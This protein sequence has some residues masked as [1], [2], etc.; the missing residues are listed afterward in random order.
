MSII[1]SFSINTW[2]QFLGKG[3]TVSFGNPMTSLLFRSQGA[4]LQN[5]VKNS[6]IRAVGDSVRRLGVSPFAGCLVPRGRGV[7]YKPML[8]AAFQ[9]ESVMPPL[10]TFKGL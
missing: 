9:K 1:S 4:A 8:K 6:P 10:R 3:V 5:Q 2:F 7:G